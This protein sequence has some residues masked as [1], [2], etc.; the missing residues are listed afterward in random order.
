V[1]QAARWR[2]TV[3]FTAVLVVLLLI[4]GVAIYFTTSSLIYRRVDAELANKATAEQHLTEPDD[5]SGG[6]GGDGDGG[7]PTFDAGGYFY[8]VADTA[9][10]ITSTSYKVDTAALASP[11][12]L[13]DAASN[14]SAVEQTTS[15]SG[16]A[17]RV[18]V[19][20]V[21]GHDGDESL[22][23]IGRSIESEQSAL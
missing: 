15:T 6:P 8:A 23:E 4:A 10:N 21:H 18:Y 1:F 12:T 22:L 11:N 13:A 7:G 9:G 3:V 20:L 5:H 19:Q 2:L 14:G 17:Q 16:Q